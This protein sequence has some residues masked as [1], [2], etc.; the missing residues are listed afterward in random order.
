MRF[1]A[2]PNAGTR[3]LNLLFQNQHPRCLCFP[4]NQIT[5][6]TPNQ[7][8]QNGKPTVLITQ[9]FLQDQPQ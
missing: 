3:Y 7:N 1:S 2:T 6:Q 9:L 8:R 5:S 4:K